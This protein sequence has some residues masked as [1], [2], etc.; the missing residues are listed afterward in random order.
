MKDII[1]A[2][3]ISK[4]GGAGGPRLR[5]GQSAARSHLPLSKDLCPHESGVALRFPPQSMTPRVIL[6]PV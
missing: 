1:R 6:K 5:G 4:P 3:K 2:L